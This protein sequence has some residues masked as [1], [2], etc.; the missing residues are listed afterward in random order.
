[1]RN[2]NNPILARD[3]LDYIDG[4]YDVHVNRA[5][6]EDGMVVHHVVAGQNLV[7]TLLKCSQ[8]AF[9]VE[10]SAPYAT[11][12]RIHTAE[13]SGNVQCAQQISWDSDD[14]VAPVYFRPLVIAI[15]PAPTLI[16]LNGAHGVHDVWCR[17]KIEIQAGTIL[18][19]DQFWRAASTW[20]SLIRLVSDDTLPE[21]SY[22]V[23]AV[24]GEGFHFKVHMHP[25]LFQKMV[26]PGDDQSHCASI[27]TGCLSRG[28]EIVREEFG[29]DERWREY[30]VL[31]ALH[32]KLLQ[33]GITTTWEHDGFRADEVATRLRPIDFSVSSGD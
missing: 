22:R 32:D 7:A 16:R 11:Y 17:Q 30:P 29:R 1:M 12:R 26:S 3:R 6:T 2:E 15:V 24:T 18:A 5:T 14:V 27:L 9:A 33:N 28:L 31:R 10:I 23:E 25:Q 8:A 20:Q 4:A 21:G 19:T 13:S